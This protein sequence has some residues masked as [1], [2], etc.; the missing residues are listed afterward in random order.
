[1]LPLLSRLAVAIRGIGCSPLLQFL[2]LILTEFHEV[3]TLVVSEGNTSLADCNDNTP[4]Y[5]S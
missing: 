5:G 2:L 1:M 4:T 3:H